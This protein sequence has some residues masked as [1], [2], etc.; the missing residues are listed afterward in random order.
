MNNFS[1]LQI[2]A[3]LRK[4]WKLLLLTSIVSA[5]VSYASTFLLKDKYK[6]VAVVYPLNLFPT[7]D[8]S[9][10]EQ[11]LQYFYSEDIKFQLAKDL[12][13][14]GRYKI[15]T[16]QIKEGRNLFNFMYSQNVSISPTLYQSIEITVK[17]EDPKFAQKLNLLLIQKTNNFIKENKVNSVKQYYVN[18]IK[19]LQHQSEE[20]DTINNQIKNIKQNY[21]I[22]DEAQLGKYL[23]KE[24]VANKVLSEKQ[25][26]QSDALKKHASELKILNGKIKSTLK[27]YEKIKIKS[28]D[29]LIDALGNIDFIS[30]VTS[31]TLT[32]KRIYPVRSIIV[33][34]SVLSS[35]LFSIVLI[36][37]F[38]RKKLTFQNNLSK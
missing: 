38:N 9:Q 26:K 35:I 22:V 14:F 1:T 37:F 23:S 2:F 8:E 15:D 7:S 5:I 24:L 31:P 16:N 34:V 13:L 30:Y 10:T 27:S 28:D 11:L 36:I 25:S 4:Y 19:V 18:T 32:D 20:L 17:D 29:Y 21:D 12:D 33:L 3:L 6:S